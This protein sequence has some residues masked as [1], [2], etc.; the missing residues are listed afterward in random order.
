MC[1]SVT[2]IFPETKYQRCSVHCFRNIFSVVPRKYGKEIARRLKAIHSQEDKRAALEKAEL[3][4]EKLRKMKLSKAAEKLTAGIA[5]KL[6][7]MD[8]LEEHW[9]KI[10]TNNGIERLN[11][12]IRRRT[13]VVGTFTDGESALM[14]G[15][16]QASPC[17]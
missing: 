13:R 17:F 7:Y 4:A 1:E 16:C 8:F 3:V 9:K 11:R 6:I 2:E 5:E 15:L 14:L 12:E 10:R